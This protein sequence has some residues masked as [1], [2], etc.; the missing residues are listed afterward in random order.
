MSMTAIN[1]ATFTVD[2]P[3]MACSSDMTTLDRFVRKSLILMIRFLKEIYLTG[4]TLLFRL[5]RSKDI[6]Y[7]VGGVCAVLMLVEWFNLVN[8]ST[9][10]NM[11]AG[12]Q[13][14]PN[15]SGPE[16]WVGIIVLFWINVVV[17]YSCRYGI[18]FERE[19]DKLEKSRKILLKTSCAVILLATIIFSIY[20]TK[21]YHRFLDA[22]KAMK[23]SIN[24]QN[25]TI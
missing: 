20:T 11:T 7:K 9:W 2:H 24:N 5:S 23:V 13:V 3:A 25:Q 10:I 15:F 14:V 19:F 18:N 4:F 8:I 6:G 22:N 12:K 16:L 21:A 1:S 17:L